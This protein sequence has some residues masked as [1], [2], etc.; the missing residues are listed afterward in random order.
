MQQTNYTHI[1][2]ELSQDE[3]HLFMM[4]AYENVPDWVRTMFK[5]R[6]G[7]HYLSKDRSMDAA[8]IQLHENDR[9]WLIV[10]F[11]NQ[12]EWD[13]KKLPIKPNVV[14]YNT[15]TGNHQ[16]FYLLRDP[17]H[18]HQ[19]AKR[20]APYKYL[21]GLEK[22]IDLKYGGDTGFSRGVSKN[23]FHPKWD[24]IWIHNRKFSLKELEQGL[25]VNAGVTSHVRKKT[26]LS[27]KEGRNS[28]VFD[29]V[30]FKSYREV[31]RYKNLD[32]VSFNDWHSVVLEWCRRAN[33]FDGKSPLGDRE[34]ASTAKSI[35]S[36]CWHRYTPQKPKKAPMT[37]SQIKEAQRK[38]QRITKAK[39]KGSSE[40]A[41][42]EAIEQLKADGKRVSKAA[43]ARIVG[44][45]RQNVTTL[46]SHLFEDK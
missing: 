16:V 44:L 6:K 28:A 24:T 40:A 8:W 10:D 45:S 41:I 15:D 23:L 34:V 2:S 1:P 36:F 3:Q 32:G 4:Q 35:A 25:V 29:E 42:K 33:S 30:R 13:W 18:C 21:R 37:E 20:N 39:Q 5:K 43:A 27:G 26:S 19:A 7:T 14:S 11:D 12:D 31:E 22:S 38:A 46:Y 9:H 17:V